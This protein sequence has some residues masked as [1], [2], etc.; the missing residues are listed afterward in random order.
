MQ[1]MQSLNW[2]LS[3]MLQGSFVPTEAG[4]YADRGRGRTCCR[5]LHS[6]S[7]F[8]FCCCC[9]CSSSL[10]VRSS[11]NHNF[12][13][14]NGNIQIII[15]IQTFMMWW[16]C[17]IYKNRLYTWF[18]SFLPSYKKR[19]QPIVSFF[20]HHR[21]IV[22]CLCCCCCCRR[23]CTDLL[24]IASPFSH[25]SFDCCMPSF[26]FLIDVTRKQAE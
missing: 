5:R 4:A 23:C 2:R 12:R 1:Y 15:T 13:M 16:C 10:H 26:L 20:G 24:C 18:R 14:L 9:M 8:P 25:C 22:V 3:A 11:A 19:H 6:A 17:F 21:V 7:D